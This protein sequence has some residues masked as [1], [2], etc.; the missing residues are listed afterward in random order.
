[1]ILSLG[2][3]IFKVKESDI[4]GVG[5]IANIAETN[6]AMLRNKTILTFSSKKYCAKSKCFSFY[7]CEFHK[8]HNSAETLMDN[9]EYVLDEI[10]NRLRD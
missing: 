2:V 10:I 5:K 6:F 1:M 4:M 8:P 7:K 3:K 9:L